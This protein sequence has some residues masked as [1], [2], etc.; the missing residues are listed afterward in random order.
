MLRITFRPLLLWA[1]LLLAAGR[2]AGAEDLVTTSG[3]TFQNAEVL[4]LTD[5]GLLVRHR[6]GTNA[7]AWADL[8]PALQERFRNDPRL[9]E[10]RRKQLEIE[11]LKRELADREA[12]IARLKTRPTPAPAPPAVPAAPAAATAPPASPPPAPAFTPAPPLTPSLDKLPPLQPGEVIAARDLVAQFKADPTGAQARYRKK[13]FRV[14][15]EV[16]GFTA[17]PFVRR[18][19]VRLESPD[20]WLG[21]TGHFAYAEGCSAVY[22]KDGGRRLVARTGGTGESILHVVGERVVIQGRCQGLKGTEIV[23]TGCKLTR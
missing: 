7:V 14:R 10:L 1:A 20:K 23:F 19:E 17:T 9:A 15:G 5:T 18:Y 2:P 6:G 21:V 11:R 12:E 4:E 16:A 3:R 22:T 13:Q 8:S